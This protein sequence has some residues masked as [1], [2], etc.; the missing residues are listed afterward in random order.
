MVRRRHTDNLFAWR[1]EA[2]AQSQ[3]G[4][5]QCADREMQGEVDQ[6]CVLDNEVEEMTDITHSVEGFY[7]ST[8]RDRST[9]GDGDGDGDGDIEGL[10]DQVRYLRTL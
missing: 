3:I 6:P 1:D 10:F 9:Y 2:S 4:R 7:K 5:Q 8:D